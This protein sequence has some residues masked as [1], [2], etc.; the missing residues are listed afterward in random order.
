MRKFQVLAIILAFQCLDGT[1]LAA[2]NVPKPQVFT[3]HKDVY[4]TG[5]GEQVLMILHL[6]KDAGPAFVE[7]Y[8]RTKIEISLLQFTLTALGHE[9]ELE[10]DDLPP[11]WSA[12][13][14]VQLASLRELEIRNPKAFNVNADEISP[15]L[16]IHQIQ[17]VS[18]GPKVGKRKV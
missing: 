9:G 3:S 15:R 7:I 10:F 12:V 14:E 1:T 4:Q 5:A 17:R 13:K 6:P 2:I 16:V 8:N 18:K 11:G